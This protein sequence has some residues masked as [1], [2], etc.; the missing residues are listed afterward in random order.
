MNECKLDPSRPLTVVYIVCTRIAE[1]LVNCYEKV[2]WRTFGGL[3]G[4]FWKFWGVKTVSNATAYDE[5]DDPW[6]LAFW[7]CFLGGIKRMVE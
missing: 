2:L 1:L 3:L 4:A 6:G 5:L 7:N